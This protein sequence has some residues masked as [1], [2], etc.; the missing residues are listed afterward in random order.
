MDFVNQSQAH[1]V[2][3]KQVWIQSNKQPQHKASMGKLHAT[4]TFHRQEYANLVLFRVLWHQR[5]HSSRA[6]W[7]RVAYFQHKHVLKFSHR[8]YESSHNLPLSQIPQ[9]YDFHQNLDHLSYILHHQHLGDHWIP[10]D[11]IKCKNEQRDAH[12][13][14]TPSIMWLL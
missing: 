10:V 8:K 12:I 3:N 1:S 5:K 13:C 2:C 11:K 6:I 14:V 4:W 9:W 7:L